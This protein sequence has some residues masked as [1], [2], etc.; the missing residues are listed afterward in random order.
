MKTFCHFLVALFVSAEAALLLP[1][2]A[3]AQES[4]TDV[5]LSLYNYSGNY[6]LV[7]GINYVLDATVVPANATTKTLTWTVSNPDVLAITEASNITTSATATRTV[8][9]LA[10]G[11]ATVTITATDGGY[12]ADLTFTVVDE[13]NYTD[14]IFVVNEDYFPAVS[15]INFLYPDGHWDNNVAK[16]VNNQTV[17]GVTSQFGT[18]YGGKFF[19]TSKQAGTG[20]R[21][22]M[23]DAT[24]F[25][26]AGPPITMFDGVTGDDYYNS[27]D[28]RAFV[29]VDEHKGYVGSNNGIFVYNTDEGTINTTAIAGTTSTS[30]NYTDQIGTMLR[31]GNRV[32]AIHQSEGVLVINA[33]T[34]VIET[35]VT[36]PNTITA[37]DPG[38]GSIVQSKDGYLWMSVASKVKD[39]WGGTDSEDYLVRLDPWTLETSVIALPAD[40]SIPNS[41]YT[42]TADGFC[43]SAKENKLYW[44][45]DAGWFSST[46]I[47][48]YDIDNGTFGT[49]IDF[50]AIPGNYSL[51]SAGF[52][53]DPAT[54]IIYAV[55]ANNGGYPFN[56]VKINPATGEVMNAYEFRPRNYYWF[57]ALPVFPDNAAP[58]FVNGQDLPAALE[59]NAAVE[60]VTDTIA[61]GGKVSDADNL[62]AAIVVTTSGYDISLFDVRIWRDSLFVT[63]K[64]RLV[65][66][67]NDASTTLSLKFNSNGRLLTHDISLTLLAPAV[68]TFI[69]SFNLNYD[70]IS[71]PPEPQEIKAGDKA[72]KPTELAAREGFNFLGWFTSATGGDEWN[73]AENLITGDTTLYAHWRVQLELNVHSLTLDIAQTAQL[74]LI[75]P[76]GYTVTWRS[77]NENIAIVSSTGRVIGVTAGT[78]KIIAE[79]LAKNKAD[80]CTVTVLPAQETHTIS[81]NHTILVMNAEERV[82]IEATVSPSNGQTITW[83]ASNPTVAD[84]TSAGT[85][86]AFVAGNTTITATLPDG[87]AASCNVTVRDVNASAEVSNIRSDGATL[88]FP[89]LSGASHYLVHLYEIVNGQRDPVIALKVNPDGTIAFEV[90]LRTS[91]NSIHLALKNLT[92]STPYE[93]DIDVIR[94]I[95]GRAEVVS[96]MHA[97]FTTDDLTGIEWLADTQANAYYANGSLRLKHLE[98]YDC[99]IVAVSGQMLNVIQVVSPDE[100]HA[101]RL[102]KGVYL[103]RAQKKDDKKAIKFIVL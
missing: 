13:A 99:Q 29:G 89:K 74:S 56:I 59:F 48:T 87:T 78:T 90:G 63:P 18:I 92:A 55:T 34:D 19:V 83:W 98:G 38:F 10:A 42:W 21:L 101:I 65:E 8:K 45:A 7:K 37:T 54:D 91:D 11:T 52:R 93:A 28:G 81:L 58:E 15:S 86:I 85:V 30:N 49:V 57:P 67:D 75:E 12:T 17:C 14:G 69:V 80:T 95:D 1:I 72:I 47:Y 79:D 26:L 40:W 94:E 5:A 51:Y 24:T 71:T 77:L 44:K 2:T 27:L 31:V 64:V 35:I 88:S 100:T 102:A 73:F 61:F 4:V 97:A 46:K 20:S 53:I 60:A 82:T 33:E 9:A 6:P 16:G 41:W 32:F 70:G 96:V 23:L 103:L 84:V 43:A 3:M 22:A 36:V 39:S 50:T 68:E 62:D 25:Q 76:A 66:G